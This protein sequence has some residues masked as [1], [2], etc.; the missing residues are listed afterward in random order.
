MKGLALLLSTLALGCSLMPPATADHAP[1][2]AG[3]QFQDAVGDAAAQAD[4]TGGWVRRGGT[5]G[6][7]LSAN[8]SVRDV[9]DAGRYEAYLRIDP[10]PD[11][12]ISYLIAT[13]IKDPGRA[14]RTTVGARSAGSD[15]WSQVRNCP[16]GTTW[17]QGR[18]FVSLRV[19]LWECGFVVG[20]ASL[21][22]VRFASQGA[23]DVAAGAAAFDRTYLD[24]TGDAGARADIRRLRH[25]KT[26]SA[27]TFSLGV[28]DLPDHGR[29]VVETGDA[30]HTRFVVQ[31]A[32]GKP[33]VV[34][35]ARGGPDDWFGTACRPAARWDAAENH[36]VVQVSRSAAGC[37]VVWEQEAH[38]AL[39][40]GYLDIAG[41]TD[42]IRP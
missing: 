40:Y 2:P 15:Q 19:H 6:F 20:P 11:H 41:A 32:V 21:M 42:V 10:R 1:D 39:Y 12:G 28:Q 7:T 31:K 17:D 18:D 9:R 38:R 26:T 22:K 5:N 36:V 4:L 34:S 30:S 33:P 13:L 16:V 25:W 23:A 35:I 14:P 3:Y 24:A 37:G 8:S 27:A 29:L